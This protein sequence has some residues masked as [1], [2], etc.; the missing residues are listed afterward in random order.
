MNQHFYGW[1]PDKP[2]KRDLGRIILRKHILARPPAYDMTPKF[3]PPYDQGQLGSCTANGIAGA[4]EWMDNQ[5]YQQ[6]WP[7][8]RLFIYYNERVMEGSVN[9]D[10]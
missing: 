4:V 9:Q 6:L 2:D 3:F 8:S 5:E 10:A 7:P 1:K